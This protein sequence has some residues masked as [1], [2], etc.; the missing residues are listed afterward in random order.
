[1]PV[2]FC[3]PM[4]VIFRRTGERRYSVTVEIAGQVPQ[5]V[6][7]AP[8]FDPYIP[9]DLV[10]YVVEA[11]LGLSSGVF[12]RAAKGAGT[13]IVAS[14][15]DQSPRER[16]RARRRQLQREASL[17]RADR[18]G[19]QE[20]VTSERLAAV[21]DLLWR[22]RHGQVPDSSR[23][24]PDCSAE[25]TKRVE[26]IVDRLAALAPLWNRLPIGGALS[27][28]WPSSIPSTRRGLDE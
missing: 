15:N 22:R 24:G 14:S 19:E 6:D 5:R 12:G 23:P 11:E 13:F 4:N 16:A 17:A 10:H 21:S 25:D 9:H 26:R 27:F 1:M 8:G 2:L 3:S 28:A 18:K 7:P 20:M